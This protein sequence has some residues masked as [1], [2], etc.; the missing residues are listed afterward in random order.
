MRSLRLLIAS[1][2]LGSAVLAFN[3]L[4]MP[5]PALACSC[6]PPGPIAAI[7]GMPDRPVA[8]VTI[9]QP[10]GERMQVHIERW[11][12]GE[13]PDDVILLRGGPGASQI[14]SCD[15]EF[16]PGERWL[17]VLGRDELGGHSASFCEPHGRLGTPEGDALLA[18]AMT[19]FGA[20]GAPRPP[21][22]PTHQQ[23]DLSPW[24][25]GLGWVVAVVGAGLVV[26]A[27][28]AVFARRRPS[29]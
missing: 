19:V 11:L 29:D 12:Q 7:A 14:S 22:D 6:M 20:G 23:G 5:R 27:L 8:V 2:T 21:P 17:L 4:A 16:T 13:V 9:G 10:A 18:E 24:L 28:V 25:G 3:A 1:Q 26:L 15:I